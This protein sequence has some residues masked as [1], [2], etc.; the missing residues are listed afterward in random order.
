MKLNCRPKISAYKKETRMSFQLDP[1]YIMQT[2]TC[3]WTSKV[4]LTA[5]ELELFTHLGDKSMTATELGEAVAY[6]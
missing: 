6:K 3:F 4:L 5:V 1:G 2:A